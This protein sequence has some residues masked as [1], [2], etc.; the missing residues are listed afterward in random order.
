MSHS[1]IFDTGATDHMCADLSRF[2][3]VRNVNH[4][5]VH[6]PDGQTVQVTH[7]GTVHVTKD[8]MLQN[9]L[10]VPTFHF[11]LISISQLTGIS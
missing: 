6:L 2:S 7:I 9:V 5:K 4:T 11:N 8:L 1:W 3:H 10:C